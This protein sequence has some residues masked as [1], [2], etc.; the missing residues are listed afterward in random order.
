MKKGVLMKKVIITLLLILTFA[1]IYGQDSIILDIQISGNSNIETELIQSLLTFEIGDNLNPEMI[2]KSIKNLYQLGVFEDISI[3][4]NELQQG[5]SINV[6]I[7]E[8]PVVN[9]I[10]IKG[11]KKISDEKFNELLDVKKGSYWSPFLRIET[12]NII[13]DEYKIKDYHLA[14]TE[15][16]VE[17]LENNRI[18]LKLE[19][20]ENAK[21]VIEE[22]NLHGN[23]LIR[24]KKL[25]GKMKTKCK[26]LFRS[27][28][29]ELEEFENDLNLLVSYYNKKGF[30]D[31]NIISWDKRLIDNRFVIEIY[32]FEGDIYH[33]GKIEVSGND[34]FTDEMIISQFKFEKD[35]IF[36]LEKFNEQLGAVTSM[37][38]EEGYIYSNFDH[39]LV[40]SKSTIDIKLEIIENN[41]ARVRKI[42]IVGN[43]KTKEKII[44]RQLV[45]SPGDYFQQ[46][47]I[48]KSQQNIYNLGFFEPDIHL[49]N[50]EVIN[51]N[52]DI[53]LTINVNDKVS[54]S[55]NGGIAL[56]AQ[57]GLVG[58]ISVSHNNLFGNA[59]KSSI[60]WEFGGKTQ[61]FT[62]NFTNPYL[63]DSNTLVGYDIYH[64]TKEWD[65]YDVQS[66]GGSFRLGRPLSFLN[67]SKL[68]TS[69]S[70]Y[71]KKYQILSG[72]DE[73]V[74]DALTELDSLGWQ[75]TSSISVTFSRDS[76]D[77]IF[78][79]SSGSSF[80]LFSE[81]AGGILSGDFNYYKHIAQ[82]S[83]FTRTFWKFV[84]R[85]KWRFGFVNGFDGKEAPPDERFYLGG[86]GADGIRGYADRSVGPDGGGLRE[87]LFSTEYSVPIGSDQIIGLIFFDS[88]D[89]YNHLEEFNFL[90]M[91]KGA[92]F[93]IRVQSPLGLIGF[94]YARNFR[95]RTW[96]PHFQFG[97]T[98]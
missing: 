13:S 81:Y 17:R 58:Q 41:R 39:N 74:S 87:I 80:T 51:D 33:F 7:K 10:E 63:F 70:F 67:Y 36:N 40:K 73:D 4:K 46:S 66:N 91:K 9:E 86:T 35:E 85:T 57:E 21:V 75:N 24:T 98:F 22:I 84:L 30:I 18:N 2:S 20:K 90:E 95:D 8:F 82:V 31:A 53:D 52:G 14:E 71:A 11:N 34:K 49:D 19:I 5:I 78:F 88:G 69:Y 59:W 1:L 47:K 92:G 97:T 44:R 15:F 62:L 12:K 45:I 77:N 38:Y 48:M 43:R 79:P 26:S 65:K 54:G 56:N 6:E 76:R 64:T 29:F 3:N 16:T 60:Q 25:L 61:N 37:Y 72:Y 42:N 83:W 68:I 50:P 32:L 23:K 96:E 28:K 94:D 55:A 93:G 89:S 27:G